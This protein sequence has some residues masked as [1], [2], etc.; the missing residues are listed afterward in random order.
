MRQ[1]L[2]PNAL[3]KLCG[4]ALSVPPPRSPRHPR[5]L[6]DRPGEIRPRLIARSVPGLLQNSSNQKRCTKTWPGMCAGGGLEPPARS[7]TRPQ[8]SQNGELH[9]SIRHFDQ[10]CCILQH[11]RRAFRRLSRFRLPQQRISGSRPS[12][13]RHGSIHGAPASGT[14][15]GPDAGVFGKLFDSLS[16][17]RMA[18]PLIPGGLRHGAWGRFQ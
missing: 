4:A 16:E 5:I 8:A 3:A 9:F 14:P 17:V 6:M 18:L 1:N 11:A 13:F 10:A 15:I 12:I 2:W 7:I